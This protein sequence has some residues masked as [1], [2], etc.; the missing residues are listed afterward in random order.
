[1]RAAGRD[2]C[3]GF[4]IGVDVDQKLEARRALSGQAASRQ[5]DV[6]DDDVRVARH[7]SRTGGVMNYVIR[8]GR[9]IEVVTHD[10]GIAVKRRSKKARFCHDI[11]SAV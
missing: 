7:R 1:M 4:E 10:F 5:G 3:D 11:A 2:V 8:H 6:G 9:R